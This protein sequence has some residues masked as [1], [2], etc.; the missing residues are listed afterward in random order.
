[1]L[2]LTPF[3]PFVALGLF[4]GLVLVGLYIA[5]AAWLAWWMLEPINK[6]AGVLQATTQFLLTDFLALMLMLQFALATVGRA[7]DTGH[8]RDGSPY[9]TLMFLATSL[10]VVLWGASVSVVSRA[11]IIRPLRRSAV[12]VLLVPGALGVIMS[13]P[14]FVVGVGAKLAN[15]GVGPRL[16]DVLTVL[17]LAALGVIVLG[18]A[19]WLLRR[20]SFWSLAGS[21]GELALARLAS[22][23][24][25]PQGLVEQDRR[26]G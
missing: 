9:W 5:G 14:V 11:G 4:L 21:P 6:V 25:L 24:A 7:I 8:Q 10:V 26:S 16:D 15:L 18:G 2:A 17:G 12:I 22:S 19:V 1:M 3:A 13:V 20:L 23:A